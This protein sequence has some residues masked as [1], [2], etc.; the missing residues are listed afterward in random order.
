MAVLTLP[1]FHQVG[2]AG[3]HTGVGRHLVASKH[4]NDIDMECS[5]HGMISY[6]LVLGCAPELAEEL[7]VAGLEE[8]LI[9][10]GTDAVGT[11]RSWPCLR[12]LL[13]S[14]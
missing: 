5:R 11:S 4:G 1:V 7:V 9:A 12:G 6:C 13:R 10:A 8:D 14:C 2:Q 3:V